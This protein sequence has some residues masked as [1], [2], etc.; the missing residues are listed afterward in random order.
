MPMKA[1]VMA[2]VVLA[3]VLIGRP[4]AAATPTA[5]LTSASVTFTTTDEDKDGDTAVYL[6]LK[7]GDGRQAGWLTGF[8]GRFDDGS[9]HGPLTFSDG[10]SYVL[11]E[12]NRS[13][14]ESNRALT[15]SFAPVSQVRVPNVIGQTEAAAKAAVRAAG[16]TPGAVTHEVDPRCEHVGVVHREI[17][18]AG[19]LVDGGSVVVL[20]IGDEPK[21][22]CP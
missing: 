15:A 19:A 5:V 6:E 9:V 12:K 21:T 11:A 16:L 10:T 20:V 3:L 14:S 18:G 8:Y 22:H 2:V 1:L 7:T 13:L 4:A 17:P